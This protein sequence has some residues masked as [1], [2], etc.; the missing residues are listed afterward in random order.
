MSIKLNIKRENTR[1]TDM[2]MY[3]SKQEVKN[4][5][6]H[7]IS[8]IMIPWKIRIHLNMLCCYTAPKL[9]LQIQ[10]SVKGPR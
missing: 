1:E 5:Y 6:G 4:N 10:L 9:Y 2:L 7:N 3:E 8:V